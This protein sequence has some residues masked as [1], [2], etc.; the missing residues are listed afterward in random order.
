MSD[1]IAVFALTLFGTLFVIFAAA[2]LPRNE[3]DE[4]RPIPL[5]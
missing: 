5:F 4:K 1:V 3:I 2:T